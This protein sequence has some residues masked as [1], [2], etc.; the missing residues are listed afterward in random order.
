M[1]KSLNCLVKLSDL[2]FLT[3]VSVRVV[4]PSGILV[5]PPTLI[6][7]F[8]PLNPTA[9]SPAT[10]KALALAV[11]LVLAAL[12]SLRVRSPFAT[13]MMTL[14]VCKGHSTKHL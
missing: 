6:A 10:P 9:L 5:L 14:R 2:T 11:A 1:L 3:S 13:P 4:N 7:V 12:Y 8:D